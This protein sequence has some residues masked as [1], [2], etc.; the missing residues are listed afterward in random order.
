MIYLDTFVTEMTDAFSYPVVMVDIICNTC[1]Q[2]ITEFTPDLG[3]DTINERLKLCV[4][5]FFMNSLY[6]VYEVLLHIVDFMMICTDIPA[7]DSRYQIPLLDVKRMTDLLEKYKKTY[8]VDYELAYSF[9]THHAEAILTAIKEDLQERLSNLVEEVAENQGDFTV[10]ERFFKKGSFFEDACLLIREM[11]TDGFF[12]R[13]ETLERRIHTYYSTSEQERFPQI[14]AIRH[15]Q[16]DPSRQEIAATSMDFRII[17]D[18]YANLNRADAREA[19]SY[20]NRCLIF[21]GIHSERF[22]E[23]LQIENDEGRSPNDFTDLAFWKFNQVLN[24][25]DIL[26]N[27]ELDDFRL[28]GDVYHH[29]R[30]G[31]TQ[32]RDQIRGVPEPT[33]ELGT[34]STTRQRGTPIHRDIPVDLFPAHARTFE[35]V[36]ATAIVEEETTGWNMGYIALGI[37]ILL[38]L[39]ML[40]L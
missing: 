30:A 23:C 17:K 26:Q 31:L 1:Y 14:M 9:E 11:L 7:E 21:S 19:R 10:C 27:V 34:P 18:L 38:I 16:T 13:G 36:F 6:G 20:F 37:V 25:A 2:E 3:L 39:F 15:R 12:E 32:F 24:N 28:T 33:P 40:V 22:V 29:I 8:G 4:S 5:K 35:P